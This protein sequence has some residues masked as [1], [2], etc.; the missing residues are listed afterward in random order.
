MVQFDTVAISVFAGLDFLILRVQRHLGS[1]Q[2]G[3]VEQGLW[4]NGA[5]GISVA[6]KLLKE[7]STEI[8]KVKFLQEAAIMAQFSHPN[9]VSLFGVVCKTEPVRIA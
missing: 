2:F 5:K 3:S 7:G 1:G 6:L 4:K 8:D 9:V